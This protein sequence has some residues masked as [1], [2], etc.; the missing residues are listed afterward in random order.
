MKTYTRKS[1]VIL[2]VT[3]FIVI[4]LSIIAQ[5][6]I[7]FTIFF[8]LNEKFVWLQ[9]LNFFIGAILYLVIVNKDQSAVYK[10]PWMMLFTLFPVLSV[11][12]YFTFNG[13]NH[14]KKII[15]S[16]NDAFSSES[17]D[18]NTPIILKKLE[19]KSEHLS[20]QA[21]YLTDA[22]NVPIFNDSLV[23]YLASG[24]E[25]FS[26]LLTE[27]NSVKKYVF[28]EY[29]IIDDGEMWQDI[30]NILKIKANNGVQIYISYDDVGSMSRLDKNFIKTLNDNGI[31]CVKFNAFSPIL[32]AVHNNRDHRKIMVIDGKVA[33]T[34]G[35]NIAD[36]YIN[37]KS[38]YGR[39]KDSA[40]LIKGNAVSSL[41][42]GFCA[43]YNVSAKQKLNPA[44]FIVENKAY[45]NC[46]YVLPYFDGP[47]PV[48]KEHIGENAYLNIIN[49]ATKYLYITT[50][51]LVV[52]NNVIDA[53][54]NASLR[55]VDVRIMV[56]E[57]PDKKVVNVLTKSNY[58]RLLNSGVKVYEYKGGF[59]H[60]K[61]IVSDN[62]SVVGTINF[63][64]RSLIHHYENAVWFAYNNATNEVKNDF[65]TMVEKNSVLITSDMAK[66]HPLF[67]IIT[68]LL[69]IFSPLF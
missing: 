19:N 45:E 62:V 58:S 15:I 9:V 36:E 6:V 11:I 8:K 7:S 31:N 69:Y 66:Q 13:R 53:L 38:P 12:V 21:R 41:V 29:F 28:L 27:L 57:I 47:N 63:D 26:T 46:G 48:Y 33:F 34:G 17:L 65:L 2:R 42:K 24:E 5:A 61:T 56:P 68:G 4:A 32:S 30:F 50:P 1:S 52:D 40:I 22:C 67:K 10:I 14:F 35:I 64:Y 37:L 20:G 54:K 51:Y 16:K 43:Q 49:Q 59:I 18:Y 39:W 23:K 55:G 3:R 60:A 44:D 25:F